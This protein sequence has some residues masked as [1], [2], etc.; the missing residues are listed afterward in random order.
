MNAVR[1]LVLKGIKGQKGFTLVELLVVVGIIVALSAVIVPSV[2]QFASRGDSGAQSAEL[3]SVQAAIDT[4]M[5]DYGITDI[6]TVNG[7]LANSAALDTSTNDFSAAG[8][9]DLATPAV[10][11]SGGYLRDTTLQFYYCW[12]ISG[13]ILSQDTAAAADCTNAGDGAL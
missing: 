11:G 7:N 12:N 13:R 2:A 5:A 3:D 9:L 1:G 10:A 6:T 4:M 8:L